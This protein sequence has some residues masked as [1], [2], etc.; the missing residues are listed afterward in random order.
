M[1]DE[2]DYKREL[3]AEF[4]RLGHYARRIEDRFLV[5]FPDLILIPKG[6][7]IFFCEAKIIRGNSFAPRPR[8]YVELDRLAISPCAVPCVLGFDEGLTCLHPYAKVC[9]VVDCLHQGNETIVDF[10][11]WFYKGRVNVRQS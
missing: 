8:Q 11:I 6:M 3:V 5:G 1:K 4:Q 7:P 2:S 10:F 9:R